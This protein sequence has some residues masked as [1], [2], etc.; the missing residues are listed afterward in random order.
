V[1]APTP[2]AAPGGPPADEHRRPSIITVGTPRPDAPPQSNLA[3]MLTSLQLLLK[4]ERE[5]RQAATLGELWHVAA[6]ES[7]R[8]LQARQIFVLELTGA[9]CTM[10]AVSSLARP[11]RD[12]PTIRWLERLA[13]ESLQGL[14]ARPAAP[15][16]VADHAAGGDEA[17][18]VFPFSHLLTAAIT[19]RS[20]E[21]VACLLAVRESAFGEGEV[22]SAGR[23]AETFGHAAE[24]L[25]LG[26][27]RAKRRTLLRVLPTFSL[28]V[29]AAAALIPV[30]MTVLAPAEVAARD[31]FVVTPA[32]DGVVAEIVVDA[33]QPVRTGDVLARLQDTQQRNQLAIAEQEVSVA[34]ARWRQ[35]SIA[36]FHDPAARRELAVVSS[37]RAL[38]IAERDYA[39]DLL[40][41][42]VIRAERD[43][44][45][46]FADKRELTGRPIQTGQRLMDV[47]DPARLRIRAQTP[48]D[49]AIAVRPGARI[50]FFPDAD[51]L[52][53]IE[54]IITDA[55]HQAR[56][57]E[58]GGLAF[59]AD[60]DV[61]ASAIGRLGI[62]H[63][64]TAQILGE[65]V[66]LGYYLLRR[67]ISSVRQRFGL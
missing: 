20:G 42:T 62:G 38:R 49:D 24:A 1:T 19:S 33:N 21:T 14:A 2:R 64:G 9:S 40:D 44:I 41:R 35:T 25:G 11:D 15:S 32:I 53:P 5:A 50:K 54:A 30:P 13:R 67:P 58:S 23:L 18:Q 66:S 51:P 55:A 52:N 3:G 34:E 36:A 27:R 16:T 48:V 4:V 29:V 22:A 46:I 7:R 45:A 65:Q 17:A 56:Q 28:L 26:G 6:N 60:A 39:R 47:A 63:R 10:R 59:R 8:A 43:G 31:A 37:E 12:S 57:T 61:P